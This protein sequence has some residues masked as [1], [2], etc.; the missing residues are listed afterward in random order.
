MCEIMQVATSNGKPGCASPVG[1]GSAFRRVVPVPSTDLTF[2]L[3]QAIKSLVVALVTECRVCGT[4]GLG[5]ARSK[6]CSAPS[7]V[8]HGY[9]QSCR[10]VNFE[11]QHDKAFIGAG[12]IT[13]CVLGF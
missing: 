10:T 9:L 4:S 11:A 1:V 8:L 12:V 7:S 2:D 5:T 13:H 6:V 3:R